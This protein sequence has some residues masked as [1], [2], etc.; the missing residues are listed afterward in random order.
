MGKAERRHVRLA[1]FLIAVVGI[2]SALGYLLSNSVVIA[3]LTGVIVFGI[4]AGYFYVRRLLK[5]PPFA[6]TEV[7]MDLTFHDPRGEHATAVNT[8]RIRAN[9]RELSQIRILNISADGGIENIRVDNMPIDQHPNV[10]KEIEAGIIYIV[11]EFR[12]PLMRGQA[13]TAKVAIDVTD[14]FNMNPAGCNHQVAP[15]TEKIRLKVHFNSGKACHSARAFLRYGGVIQEELP[16]P[17]VS[18]HGTELVHEVSKPQ[19]GLQYRVEWRW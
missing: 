9:Q 6:V 18:D 12:P 15:E 14:A 16:I 2:P 5:R 7:D 11:K 10:R 17:E 1:E 8:Q 4:V 13:G 3:I 19:P